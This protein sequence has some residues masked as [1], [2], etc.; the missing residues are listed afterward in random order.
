M[1]PEFSG[2]QGLHPAVL[3]GALP[4]PLI[5]AAFAQTARTAQTPGSTCQT[6][7]KVSDAQV[8][9]NILKALAIALIS[10]TSPSPPTPL[11]AWSR[12]AA[13]SHPNNSVLRPRTSFPA[14]P[15][16]K[17]SSTSSP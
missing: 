3:L 11:M 17:R 8:E 6:L 12:S 4:L 14:P 9:E 16:C 15:A 7:N 1:H 10:P 2:S 5:P 13:P